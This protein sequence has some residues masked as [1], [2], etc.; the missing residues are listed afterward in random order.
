LNK[1]EYIANKIKLSLGSI[2]ESLRLFAEGG[3]VPFIARYRREVTGG[4][5]ENDLRT[6]QDESEKFDA[7]EARKKTVVETINKLGKMTPVLEREIEDCTLLSKLEDIYRPYKPKRETRGS[8]A[9]KNG[10][11]PLLNFALQDRTGSLKEMSK[12]YI[13]EKFK[14]SE[15][16]IQGAMDIW[17]ERISDKASYREII[18]RNIF[19]NGSVSISLSK[20]KTK[21]VYDTYDGLTINLTRLKSHQ[22]LAIDRGEREKCLKVKFNFDEDFIVQKIASIEIPKSFSYPKLGID[23]VTDACKRLLFPSV[24]NEIWGEIVDKSKDESLQFF[25]KGLKEVLLA[26]PLV[27]QIIMGFDPGFAH[28]CKI[29]IID[30]SSKVIATNVVYPTLGE[31][32]RKEEAKEIV[33]KLVKNYQVKA[34]A[35]GNGT[36]FKESYDFLKSLFKENNLDVTI[37]SVSE[38]GASIYSATKLAEAEFPTFDVNL[39]SAVSIARRLLDPLA[40]L[41]KIPPESIGVGQYQHDLD[42]KK[43]TEKLSAVVEDAVSSVGVDLNTSSPQLLEHV[44]GLNKKIASSLVQYREENGVFSNREELKKVKG[45]GNKAFENSAGFLRINVKNGDP[46]DNTFIHPESYGIARNIIK[47]FN[48]LSRE[49]AVKAKEKLNPSDIDKACFELK[50]DKY[51]LNQILDELAIPHRDPRGVLNAPTYLDNVNSIEDLKPGMIMEGTIRN[52]V[53]FG[54]FVDLGIHKD[55]LVHIS[56]L[57]DKRV[58]DPH[59]LFSIGQIVKVKVLEV[60]VPKN[61]ISLSIKQALKENDK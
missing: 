21:D 34:V 46:L 8:I 13:N 1:I 7:L 31:G 4:L 23:T 26:P 59:D 18:K 16:C 29:A 60:E 48:I 19:A 33:L 50:T 45:F 6:I 42:E 37:Y 28:G 39:R 49:D 3:S 54:V 52:I 11:E 58:N 27:P 36:A 5:L 32:R 25:I 10:L 9:I 24:E 17:A 43:L 40:E 35:L 2:K 30:T 47:Y 22:V 20:D 51:T 61:R 55:G 12:N 53:Q 44:S 56:E 38:S 14:T 41:V 15:D 57:S